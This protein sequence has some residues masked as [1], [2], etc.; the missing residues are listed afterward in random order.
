MKLGVSVQ[1]IKYWIQYE[2]ETANIS[3]VWSMWDV[4][5]EHIKKLI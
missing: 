1:H 4:E 5:N 3:F 2:K